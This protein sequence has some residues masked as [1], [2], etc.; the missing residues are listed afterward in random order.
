MTNNQNPLRVKDL[1]TLETGRRV[2]KMSTLRSMVNQF[3]LASLMSFG[4][5]R[6]G[7]VS[8]CFAQIDRARRS[9]IGGG[10]VTRLT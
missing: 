8:A 9:R 1:S 6:G 5:I 3:M 7:A 10:W 2:W 4:W